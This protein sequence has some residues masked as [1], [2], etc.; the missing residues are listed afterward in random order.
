MSDVLG[1]PEA[2]PSCL[3]AVLQMLALT[4]ATCTA[5]GRVKATSFFHWEPA[6]PVLGAFF[7][8]SLFA[9]SPASMVV[10]PTASPWWEDTWF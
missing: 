5:K 3:L 10:A 1:C 6:G 9:A 7:V 4:K 2:V 8:L